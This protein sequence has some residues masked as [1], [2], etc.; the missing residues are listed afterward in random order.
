MTSYG[1]LINEN[2]ITGN[3]YVTQ[4]VSAGEMKNTGTI[5]TKNIAIINSL[6]NLNNGVI[7]SNMSQMSVTAAGNLSR[8]H[9][10]RNQSPVCYHQRKSE[11]HL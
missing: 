4:M 11:H 3:G 5:A 9:H 10:P 6:G 1:S 2:S 7:I 8:R